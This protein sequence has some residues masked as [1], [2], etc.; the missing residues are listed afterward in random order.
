MID[1]WVKLHRAIVNSRVFQNEALLKVWIYCI[2]RANHT[3]K[4]AK[5]STGKGDTE[6]KLLPGQFIFGRE[7]AAQELRMKPSS[8]RNRMEKLNNIGNLD[9][10][11]DS[12]YSIVSICNWESYQNAENKKRTAKGTGRG[13]PKDTDNN[14]KNKHYQNF[15]E[16]WNE[17]N[18]CNS[19][20]TKAK[21][22]QINARLKT[23]TPDEIKTAIRNRAF[24]SWING[25]GIK[26]K[27]DWESFWR[28][29]E[30]V[31]RYLNLNNGQQ[32]QPQ[33]IDGGTF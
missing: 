19:R 12:Q 5:V 21:Q 4:W 20:M 1:G 32:P 15:L 7:K 6:I 8:V 27:T 28:N 13:Q 14:V 30:K 18:N 31:E 9:M 17:T 26:Y 29:D 24:D 22:R 23:F 25:D 3:E 10:Q 2:C 33:T 11:A 16:F